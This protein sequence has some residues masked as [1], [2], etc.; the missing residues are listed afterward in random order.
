VTRRW[1]LAGCLVLV[2][3]APLLESLRL[4]ALQLAA[5]SPRPA[6]GCWLL[7]NAAVSYLGALDPA[8]PLRPHERVVALLRDGRTL[9]IADR[10][11][12]WRAAPPGPVRALTLRRGERREVTLR[13]ASPAE[14][15]LRLGLGAAVGLLL[16]VAPG[17]RVLRGR[18]PADVP[19]ALVGAALATH[20]CAALHRT[21]SQ[22]LD[23]AWVLAQALLPAAVTH[24]A[25]VF[26]RERRVL[27]RAR[28]LAA[29]PYAVAGGLALFEWLLLQR[30][31][32]LWELPDQGGATWLVVACAGLA[33][34]SYLAFE[35]SSSE[36]ERAAA[37]V[38]LYAST[39]AAGLLLVVALGVGSALPPLPRR[40][41]ALVSAL[42]LGALAYAAARHGSF[43]P[44]RWVRWSA[45]YVIYT[46]LV[47]AVTGACLHGGRALAGWPVHAPDPVLLVA[48]VFATLLVLDGLRRLAW[49]LAE[50][51]VTPWTPRL[52]AQRRRAAAALADADSADRAATVLARA[53]SEGLEASRVTVFLRLERARWR[54]AAV[55]GDAPFQARL[56]PVA[57]EVLRG[58]RAHGAARR[59]ALDL[60]GVLG[61]DRSGLRA[62]RV[63]GV[64]AVCELDVAGERR[65]LVLLGP[66]GR[67]RAL[68][69]DHAA[70]LEQL[71]IQAAAA[72][73][74]AELEGELL[75][76][77]RMAA[78]GRAAAGLAHDLGRPLGEILLL[79]RRPRADARPLDAVGALAGECLDLLEGFVSDAKRGSALRGN[80]RLESVLEAACERTRRLCGGRQP[81]LRLAPALPPVRD[82]ASVQRVVE[83]LLENAMQWSPAGVPVE[84]AASA[85][86]G[87]VRLRVVDHG[88]GMPP[89]VAASAFA[90]FFTRRR[91]EG[92]NG[93][94][95]TICRDIVAS[96]GGDVRLDSRPARGTTVE[97]T[98]PADGSSA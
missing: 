29:L 58:E 35:E 10:E 73:R 43:D 54:L 86:D 83:N 48:A 33:V 2:G 55:A 84:L 79:A 78:A 14:R 9:P 15:R 97:V 23:F 89:D 45:S 96:L 69:S 59:P 38:L 5:A 27:E 44:P 57:E 63:A 98:L 77:A 61:Q 32:R 76:A 18:S 75:A 12:L 62:L 68:S 21:P 53:L 1:L 52:E 24:L 31:S 51:W 17:L 16:G 94:G 64:R 40:T 71:C 3:T 36:R 19:L 85:T 13:A 37:K 41:V 47:A 67:R 4:Q 92:G 49:G 70:F 65:G 91:A 30:G 34:S 6:S 22:A 8:C 80:M 90:P 11:A 93:L 95:L 39:A 20:A 28:G 66:P 46:G 50:T 25:L 26:P 42:L 56:A 82:P 81:V 72:L 88:A 7:P 74:R 87:A 60:Q